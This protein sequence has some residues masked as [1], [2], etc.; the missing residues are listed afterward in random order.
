MPAVTTMSAGL[1]AP[2][3]IEAHRALAADPLH[4][5]QPGKEG[6]RLDVGEIER[7]A[8]RRNVAARV[9]GQIDV[10]RAAIYRKLGKIGVQH[11]AVQRDLDQRVVHLHARHGESADDQRQVGVY[12]LQS[13]KRQRCIRILRSR[14]LRVDRVVC[15]AGSEIGMQIEALTSGC[16]Q[17][18][19][20][21]FVSI[22]RSALMFIERQMRL[23]YAVDAVVTMNWPSSAIRPKPLPGGS[24]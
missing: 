18:E 17:R 16:L 13:A 23:S 7:R 14:L 15:L 9:Y 4:V 1:A 20:S 11:A 24:G 19:N 3:Y 5:H 8:D 6:L 2:R 21:G 22:D 12:G 10:A